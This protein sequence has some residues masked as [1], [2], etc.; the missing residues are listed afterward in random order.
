LAVITVAC[1]L[2]SG[3]IYDASWVARLQAG[4]ARH[5]TL[6]HR[7]VC[8]SDVPVPCERIE[9]AEDWPGWWAK[10]ELFRPG[11]LDGRTL[12]FDLDTII[13]GNLDRIAAHPHR[14]TAVHEYYRPA[15]L[16]STALAWH[17]DWSLIWRVMKASP[18]RTMADFAV[19]GAA[20]Q[21]TGLIG[22]QAFIEDCLA[23]MGEPFDTF[24]DLFGERSIA[25]FKEHAR[26]AVPVDAVAV[27]FHGRPK[28]HEIRDGWVRDAWA[29]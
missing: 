28:P 9:L 3:G 19:R 12:Y 10:I 2:R 16:C 14:F 26:H 20:V 13:V 1:V 25:S 24:R 22:D 27:A 23:T 4:V 15:H 21:N 17:G 7:F 8:L 11:L 18:S 5:L 29:R 6:A